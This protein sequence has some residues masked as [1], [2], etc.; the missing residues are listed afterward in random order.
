MFRALHIKFYISHL[1]NLVLAAT[2]VKAGVFQAKTMSK[3]SREKNPS[4][5]QLRT[6]TSMTSK[7]PLRCLKNPGRVNIP[8][9]GNF[10]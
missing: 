9:N 1:E 4:P 8:I 7:Y 2:D 10:E 5:K 6:L 3:L